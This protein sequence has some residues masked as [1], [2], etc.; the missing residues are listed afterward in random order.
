MA[1][2]EIDL[3]AEAEKSEGRAPKPPAEEREG[4]LRRAR[5]S[6]ERDGLDGLLLYG[7]AAVESDP[8]RYLAGYVHVFPSA[9]SLLI[10]PLEGDP[11]LL[12]DQPWH[13][14]EAERMTWV[15]DVRPFPNPARRWLADELKAAVAAA[16]VGAGLARGRIGTLADAMP[17]VY[18]ALLAA[19]APDAT[20]LDGR[21][22]WV[23]LVASPSDYDA[24][25][26]RR[27]A[28]VADEGLASAVEASG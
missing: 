18:D 19:A 20:F 14:A 4:R 24:R 15:G 11:V 13:L 6:M 5:E 17:A 1:I 2:A 27:T 26:I 9:S 7:S 25:Q 12:I 3:A 10:L 28:A 8:I 23:D 16:L 22:V 21:G